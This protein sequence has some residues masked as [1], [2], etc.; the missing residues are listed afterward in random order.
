MRYQTHVVPAPFE[1]RLRERLCHRVGNDVGCWTI[2]KFNFILLN[3]FADE[4]VGDV[5]VFRSVMIG[6]VVLLS[7]IITLISCL[8]R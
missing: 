4:M 6:V 8:W 1:L 7:T 3:A 5:D 2:V